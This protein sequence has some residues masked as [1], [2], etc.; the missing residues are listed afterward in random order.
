MI[1]QADNH[2]YQVILEIVPENF[3]LFDSRYLV[4]NNKILTVRYTTPVFDG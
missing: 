1:K 2:Y 3:W 4:M